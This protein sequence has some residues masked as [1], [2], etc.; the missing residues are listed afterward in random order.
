MQYQ[1]LLG[2]RE[3]EAHNL[4]QLQLRVTPRT[5][6]PEQDAVCA[7]SFDRFPELVRV[8]ARGGV[9]QQ[10]IVPL[11][12]SYGVVRVVVPPKWAKMIV[13]SGTSSA[14]LVNC[15]GRLREIGRAHV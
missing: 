11:A 8:R 12:H 13:A 15:C 14:N 5:V 10:I 1:P 9:H 4:L 3:T 6:A 2:R 7:Q